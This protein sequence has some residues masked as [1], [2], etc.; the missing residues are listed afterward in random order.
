MKT[1]N[2]IF[3]C[4]AVLF[5]FGCNNNTK[6]DDS[7]GQVDKSN[8]GSSDFEIQPNT[9]SGTG[10]KYNYRSGMDNPYEYN[11]DVSG[12]DENGNEVV[13]NVDMQGKYGEGYIY[14]EEDNEIYIDAEWINNGELEATD[15]DGNNYEL[16][17]D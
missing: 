3:L 12:V 4:F 10:Y 15:Q 11:Y 7:Q 5:V 9:N 2:N 17:V 16:E 14:D 6:V 8:K 1:C 13:G